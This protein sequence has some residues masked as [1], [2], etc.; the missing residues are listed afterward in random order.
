[1]LSPYKKYRAVYLRKGKVHGMTFAARNA[2][3]AADFA[4]TTIEKLAK[5]LDA[6]SI[7]L[8]VKEVK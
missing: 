7:V 1:M 8:T 3:L 4:Y 5:S 6:S 2:A